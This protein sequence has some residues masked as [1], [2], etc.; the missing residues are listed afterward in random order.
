[1]VREVRFNFESVQCENA[2]QRD[3]LYDP[4]NLQTDELHV[5]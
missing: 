2:Q 3:R 5:D 1:M 4:K